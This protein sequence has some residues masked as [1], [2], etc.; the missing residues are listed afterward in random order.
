[1]STI[2]KHSSIKKRIV[3][4]FERSSLWYCGVVIVTA[5]QLD[6]AKPQLTF[7]TSSNPAFGV[8]EAKR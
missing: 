5:A 3:S 4:K 8:S 6:S 2:K 7:C 1:M